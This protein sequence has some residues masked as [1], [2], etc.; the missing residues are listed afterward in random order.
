M[1]KSIS[2]HPL[3]SALNK[4]IYILLKP[5]FLSLDIVCIVVSIYASYHL[6]PQVSSLVSVT[7][8]GFAA[9]QIFYLPWILFIPPVFY[10]L[11]LYTHFKLPRSIT[12]GFVSVFLGTFLVILYS[13]ILYGYYIHFY[14][15]F[16]Q[17]FSILVLSLLWRVGFGAIKHQIIIP[18]DVLLCAPKASVWR[19]ATDLKKSE[20]GNLIKV[21]TYEKG[22]TDADLT[23]DIASTR[24][25]AVIF[26]DHYN[27]P[28][29]IIEILAWH[30]MAGIQVIEA[31]TFYEYMWQ[32]VPV[33]YLTSFWFFSPNGFPILS[34]QLYRYIKRCMDVLLSV[35]GLTLT[36]PIILITAILIKLESR[37]P[38]LFRQQ[39][40]GL[41][42]R[43]FTVT[44]FRS[45]IMDA[46]KDGA[47]WAKVTDPRVTKIGKIIRIMR[48]DE[49]PQLLNVLAGHM[50][51]IGPRPERPEFLEELKS[52]IPY[53][54]SRHLVKPGITGWAQVNFPYSDSV[55]AAKKKLEY[56]LYYI[57]HFSFMLDFQ[58][59]RRTIRVILI[60]RGAR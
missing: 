46:E 13:I 49:I 50:S 23:G 4:Q 24:N 14:L 51:L 43:L 11:E 38:I 37:G 19:I 48:I 7:K 10:T 56:D 47:V 52:Q 39:R 22:V 12:R 36:S 58:I 1:T 57:K 20:M 59:I 40:A 60:G 8:D 6:F 27:I 26:V 9:F 41:N 55:D 30:R 21:Y 29:E 44:K 5:V 35:V 34:T 16:L 33:P 3:R 18:V 25:P 42:E 53:Y 15:L 2:T 45:M 28:E 17:A 31:M 54:S 32:K